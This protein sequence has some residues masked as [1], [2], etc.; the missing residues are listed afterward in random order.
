M[1]F[2]RQSSIPGPSHVVRGKKDERAEQCHSERVPLS[3]KTSIEEVLAPVCFSS[4]DMDCVVNELFAAVWID[5]DDLP[6]PFT[7]PYRPP[8]PIAAGTDSPH[9]RV[10]QAHPIAAVLS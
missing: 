7:T 6:F 9:M 10:R 1:L 3:E 8:G 5:D 2:N 4:L